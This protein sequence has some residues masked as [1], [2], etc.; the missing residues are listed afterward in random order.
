M[1]NVEPKKPED[2]LDLIY[3]KNTNVLDEFQKHFSDEICDF[4]LYFSEAHEK[5]KELDGLVGNTTNEQKIAVALLLFVMLDNLFVSVKL[6]ILGYQLP[7]GNLMRQ[8]L[9]GIAL[10]SLCSLKDEIIIKKKKW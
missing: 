3:E 6:F 5:F 9:E 8:V 2:I 1:E 4:V 7:S 10:Y